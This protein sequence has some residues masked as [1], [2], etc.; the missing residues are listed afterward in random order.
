MERNGYLADE[1]SL[2]RKKVNSNDRQ[3]EEEVADVVVNKKAKEEVGH[4]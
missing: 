1:K 2:K 3:E 4:F